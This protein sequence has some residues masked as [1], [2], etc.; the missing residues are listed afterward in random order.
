MEIRIS[1]DTDVLALSDEEL[2]NDNF[3]E[4]WFENG[5]DGTMR[6]IIPIDDLAVAAIAF[7]DKRLKRL[8]KEKQL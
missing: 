1:G 7:R 8:K 3:V 4:I 6:D 5:D 2:D